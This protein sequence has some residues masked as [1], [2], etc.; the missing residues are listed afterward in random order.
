[1]LSGSI[2]EPS[3]WLNTN[4]GLGREL[5]RKWQGAKGMRTQ[6]NATGSEEVLLAKLG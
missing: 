4:S 6:A 5:D 1:M 3:A 2:G